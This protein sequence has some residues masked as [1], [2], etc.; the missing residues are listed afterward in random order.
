LKVSLSQRGIQP[1]IAEWLRD[2]NL[3]QSKL[4]QEIVNLKFGVE[5]GDQ[6]EMQRDAIVRRAIE[7]L[8]G[9]AQ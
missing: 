7:S 3:I 9:P 6:I 4:K 1:G 2:R 5:K 8:S